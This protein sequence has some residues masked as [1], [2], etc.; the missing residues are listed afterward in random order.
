MKVSIKHMTV[1]IDESF[2]E[3]DKTV[4]EIDESFSETDESFSET[5]KSCVEIISISGVIL[6]FVE[7]CW[8]N[9]SRVVIIWK[10]KGQVLSQ[11]MRQKV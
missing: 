10:A 1:K 5:D 8:D 6:V 4:S 3:I 2:C 9:K 11:L 7:C